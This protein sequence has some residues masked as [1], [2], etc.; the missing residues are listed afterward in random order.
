MGWKPAGCCCIGGVV[1]YE[2]VQVGA[3][4]VVKWLI[5]GSVICDCV[6]ELGSTPPPGE[7]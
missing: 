7:L 5:R 4:L 6:G 2:F 1:A 3:G